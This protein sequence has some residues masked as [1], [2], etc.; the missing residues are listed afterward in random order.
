M[1]Y[2]SSW[3]ALTVI[4]CCLAGQ[5][6]WHFRLN[7]AH[8]AEFDTSAVDVKHSLQ[9][10]GMLKVAER[11]GVQCTVEQGWPVWRVCARY[12]ILIPIRFPFLCV[13]CGSFAI[14]A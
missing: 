5:L 13:A 10:S 11:T 3:L 12:S 7:L 4:L 9:A 8:G 2:N 1:L 14:N 6:K